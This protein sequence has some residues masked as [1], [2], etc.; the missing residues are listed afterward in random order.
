[1]DVLFLSRCRYV[2]TTMNDIQSA[3][4]LL[5]HCIPFLECL[6]W[7]SFFHPANNQSIL[8]LPDVDSVGSIKDEPSNILQKVLR[9]R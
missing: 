9:E 1:M 8:L 3:S 2:L 4:S 5:T 7:K 6:H